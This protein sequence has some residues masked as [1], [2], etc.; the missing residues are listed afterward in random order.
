MKISLESKALG[1][2][3]GTAIGDAL[4]VPYEGKPA[5]FFTPELS[6]RQFGTSE[7]GL[8]AG[9]YSDDTQMTLAIAESLAAVGEVDGADVARRFVRLWESG[10]IIGGGSSCT[11]AVMGMMRYRTPWWAAGTEVG[12]A[13]NGTAMR[14]SPIGWWDHDADWRIAEDA[15]NSSIITHKDPRSTAGAVGIARAVAFVIVTDCVKAGELLDV[16]AGAVGAVHE[17]FGKYVADLRGWL[18]LPRDEA[19]RRIARAGWDAPAEPDYIRAF[20]IPTVLIALYSFLSYR[21]DFL[22]AIECAIRAG[23]DV[24]TSAAITGALHGAHNGF[25]LL[26]RDLIFG[27]KDAAHI[28]SVAAAMYEKKT[29]RPSSLRSALQQLE[30]APVHGQE[31]T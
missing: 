18:S 24:D 11:D 29:H 23:G 13:G 22:A 16:V 17:E 6:L 10:E 2:L 26:P 7:R 21:H 31:K 8:P 27:V 1:V 20:V 28:C 5:S 9:Q 12:R 25:Q 4:G 15:A 19:V 30:G 3:L 14:V